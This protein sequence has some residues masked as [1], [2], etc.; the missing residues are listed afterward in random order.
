MNIE[1]IWRILCCNSIDRTD[2]L[3]SIQRHLYCVHV[4]FVE[5]T[6]PHRAVE[7]TGGTYFILEFF[8]LHFDLA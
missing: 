5:V 3:L 1:Q 6:K 4:Q 7:V 8:D 2:V